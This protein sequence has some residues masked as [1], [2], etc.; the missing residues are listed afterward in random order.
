MNPLNAVRETRKT[1][2]KIE[3]LAGKSQGLWGNAWT[4]AVIAQHPDRDRWTQQTYQ[5]TRLHSDCM[6][7]LRRLLADLQEMAEDNINSADY[8]N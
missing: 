1:L 7:I 5:A 2:F 6:D 8:S 3:E 4:N